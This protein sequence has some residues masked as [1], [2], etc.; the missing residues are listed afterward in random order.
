M[1]D[2]VLPLELRKNWLVSWKTRKVYEQNDLR[3]ITDVAKE[4]FYSVTK[5][6]NFMIL[7]TARRALTRRNIKWLLTRL[8]T[9]SNQTKSVFILTLVKSFSCQSF[10]QNYFLSEIEWV[11]LRETV[12]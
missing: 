4:I 10:R 6:A 8:E 3:L 12:S 7:E 9:I 5:N 1:L 11:V 2:F